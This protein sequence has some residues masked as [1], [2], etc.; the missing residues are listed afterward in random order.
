MEV[1]EW[2]WDELKWEVIEV[3]WEEIEWE[4]ITYPDWVAC[5]TITHKQPL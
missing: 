2:E 3:E 5:I 1:I 4:T